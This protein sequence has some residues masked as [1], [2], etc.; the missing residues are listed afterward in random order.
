[1]T[2]ET[3]PARGY[4]QAYGVWGGGDFLPVLE[5]EM[6]VTD[7]T[8][9]LYKVSSFSGKNARLYIAFGFVKLE[10]FDQSQNSNLNTSLERHSQE[11]LNAF[12]SFEI[13]HSKVKLF[14]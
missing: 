14:Y 7:S 6:G 11:L 5:R 4:E 12:F 8:L 13:G 10:Y 9:T 3:L 2:S 1:M